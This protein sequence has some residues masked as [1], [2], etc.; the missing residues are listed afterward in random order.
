MSTNDAPLPS[1]RDLR[2]DLIRGAALLMIF[3]DHLPDNSLGHLT[4]RNFGFADAAELF[5]IFAGFSAMI[6]YGRV[7]ARDGLK[8]GLYKVFGRCAKLYGVQV[9]LLLATFAVVKIWTLTYNYESII[10]APLLRDGVHG[11]VRGIMLE[12]LPAYLDILPLYL[13]LIAVFPVVY[14]GFRVSRVGTIVMSLSIY[15]AAN[16][17]HVNLVNTVDTSQ[18]SE[19]FFNPF[20]WQLI[21]V[22]GAALADWTVRSGRLPRVSLLVGLCWAYLAFAFIIAAPWQLWSNPVGDAFPLTMLSNNPKAYLTPWRLLQALAIV[23]LALTSASF[24]RVAASPW[25]VPIVRCGR[26]SLE[27]FALGSLL[28]LFGRLAF[29]TVGMGWNVQLIVNFVGISAMILLADFRDG[30]PYVKRCFGAIRRA[31]PA[32]APTKPQPV[33]NH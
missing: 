25:V 15:A 18:A 31:L 17:L 13:V 4:L 19:W 1:R 12:A 23:Y 20:A 6:A 7:F 3:V 10:M 29:R 5:V 32:R 16:V 21:F 30:H 11:A 2:V 9:A 28:A 33:E 8:A 14:F 26:H 27:V 22:L 24:D